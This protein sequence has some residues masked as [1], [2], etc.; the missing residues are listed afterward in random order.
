MAVAHAMASGIIGVL[1][2]GVAVVL[3]FE[4]Y[5]LLIGEAAPKRIEDGLRAAVEAD[6]SS[7]RSV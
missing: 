2:V 3:A 6:P 7:R 5:S 1:L 4:N